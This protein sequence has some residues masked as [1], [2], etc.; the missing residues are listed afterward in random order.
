LL[1]NGKVLVAGGFDNGGA[2]NSAEL[3]DPAAGKWAATGGLNFARYN[4]TA[5]LLQNGQVLIAG[6]SDGNEPVNSAELFD[7]A[8][9][10]WTSTAPLNIARQNHTATLLLDGK[11]L[12]AG[13]V[14][15]SGVTGSAELFDPASA[16]WTVIN[17][18]NIARSGYTATLLP[19]GQVLVAGGVDGNS[20]AL[21]SAE[22]YDPAGGTWTVTSNAM[23]TARSSHT[24]TLLPNGLVLV[25]GGMDGNDSPISSAELYNPTNQ[26]WTATGSLAAARAHHTVTLLTDGLV[27]AAGGVDGSGNPVSSAELFDFIRGAWTTI[28]PLK[29]ARGNHT[30]TMLANARVLFV[31]GGDGNGN[32]V[33]SVELFD[34]TINPPTDTWTEGGTLN[35]ARAYHTATLLP[36]G[37][38]LVAGGATNNASGFS[39]IASAELYDPITATWANTSP[40]NQV[41]EYHTATLLGNGQVLVAGG[42][43]INGITNSA[44]LYSNGTWLVTGAMN[45]V[46]EHHTSTLLPNGKV[47]VA[48]G[49]TGGDNVSLGITNAELYDPATGTW[50]VT[51]AMNVSRTAH[52]AT[53]LPNGKVLVTGGANENGD[54]AGYAS[55][56]LFDPAAGTWTLTGTMNVARKSHTATLLPNG[57]VLVAGGYDEIIQAE[58]YDPVTGTWTNTGSMHT[59]RSLHTATLLPNGKVLVAGGSYE[60]LNESTASTETYDPMTGTW[61]L[62]NSLYIGRVY[63]TATLL[64]GGNV[65]VVGGYN[66]SSGVVSNSE[67]YDV[68]LHYSSLWQPQISAI[69]SPLNLGG[70]LVITGSQFRGIAEGSGGNGQDSSADYPLVQLRSLESG[71]TIFLLTT[72]WSTNSFAS[73]P[74]AGFPPG[75]A[76]ATV[77]VNGIQSTSSIVNISV[78]VPL[79]TGISGAAWNHG[80]FR[81]TFTNN[82]GALF[83]VLTSTNLLLPL[84]GWQMLGGVTEV[85]P[86]QFQFTDPQATNGSQRFYRLYSP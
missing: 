86:G 85:S 83:G 43:G 57:K 46:R 28:S 1:S 14:G 37:M 25:A 42:S 78:S 63:H 81:F 24:A 27:L 2:T 50:T 7:P 22:L 39:P 52:A 12:V 17:P 26:T 72:N 45:F 51:G 76:L 10:I 77:F 47:L 60:G 21:S 79:A 13:G 74:L 65:L 70:S 41:R 29:V 71:Q 11:V 18:L 19:D 9:G 73:A 68:G 5:T 75:Y 31:G 67:A 56:E 38:V 23:T 69:T 55:T 82:P 53:L 16:T 64:P 3:F 58:L 35:T 20:N 34:P 66:G 8:T 48:G 4:H 80:Q 44:E 6:G 49:D 15:G 36:N 61:S 30:A 59:A 62:T 84:S 40:M 32:P 33:S 54:F